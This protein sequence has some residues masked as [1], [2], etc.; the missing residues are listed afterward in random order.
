MHEAA[1][2][3]A[4]AFRLPPVSFHDHQHFS[5][6]PVCAELLFFFP[7]CKSSLEPGAFNLLTPQLVFFCFLY[8]QT[9]DKIPTCLNKAPISPAPIENPSLCL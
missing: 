5:N 7:P 1:F 8:L 4:R 6:N 2:S 3:L 9:C